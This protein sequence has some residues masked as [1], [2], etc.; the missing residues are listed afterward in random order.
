[1]SGCRRALKVFSTRIGLY[2][3]VNSA[4]SQY[5]FVPELQI[6]FPDQGTGDVCS[7]LWR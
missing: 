4:D 3:L 2:L 5:D 7:H 6:L 1:V